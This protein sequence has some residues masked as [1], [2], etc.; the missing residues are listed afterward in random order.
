[1]G[2]WQIICPSPAVGVVKRVETLRSVMNETFATPTI[3]VADKVGGDEEVPAGATAGL[4]GIQ[5]NIAWKRLVST[6]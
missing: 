4:C 5:F 1:M 3:L 2:A 6:L